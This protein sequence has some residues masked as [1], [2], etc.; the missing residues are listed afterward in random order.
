MS[1]AFA[2]PVVDFGE[3]RACLV[4]AALLPGSNFAFANRPVS[5]RV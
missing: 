1:E 2:E 5:V 3:H 4:A